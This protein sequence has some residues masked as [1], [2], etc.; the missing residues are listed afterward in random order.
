MARTSIMVEF[1]NRD[2][3]LSRS[4]PLLNIT[5]PVIKSEQVELAALDPSR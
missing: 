5:V 3:N 2:F 4:V 1:N